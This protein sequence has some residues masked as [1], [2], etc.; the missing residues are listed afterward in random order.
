MKLVLK[1][2]KLNYYYPN[3]ELFGL[4]SQNRRNA[5]LIYYS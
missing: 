1:I 5:I 4:T 2:Y 3:Y